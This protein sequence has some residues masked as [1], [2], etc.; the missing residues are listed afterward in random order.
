[1]NYQILKENDV[2]FKIVVEFYN[3]EKA[4]KTNNILKG[5]KTNFKG[6]NLPNEEFKQNMQGKL[7]V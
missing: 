7:F 6:K 2:E 4:H 1:M 5:N 3:Y